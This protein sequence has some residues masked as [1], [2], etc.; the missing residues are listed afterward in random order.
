MVAGEGG[1]Q[2]TNMEYINRRIVT[3]LQDLSE[4]RIGTSKTRLYAPWR[5]L[6]QE[7]SEADLIYESDRLYSI[8]G[9]SQL[10]QRELQTEY[11]CGTWI[12]DLALELDWAPQ[13]R[14]GTSFTCKRPSLPRA[15]SWCWSSLEGPVRFGRDNLTGCTVL[16]EKTLESV[17]IIVVD[18]PSDHLSRG[19]EPLWAL[20]VTAHVA[21]CEVTM[22]GIF[23]K[24][25]QNTS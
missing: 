18:T 10:L 1:P 7:A 3:A 17:P 9:S 8:T 21:I 16:F 5:R 11:L 12:D 22:H 4:D 14:N 25:L 19:L 24:A 2:H 20:H 6:V 15:P 13:P 23:W